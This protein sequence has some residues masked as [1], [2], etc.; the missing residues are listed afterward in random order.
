MVWAKCDKSLKT[1]V[2]WRLGMIILLFVLVGPILVI[3]LR[4]AIHVH[5]MFCIFMYV[6]IKLGASRTMICVWTSMIDPNQ[7]SYIHEPNSS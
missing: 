7:L 2:C 5:A 3:W 6:G 1:C 4:I